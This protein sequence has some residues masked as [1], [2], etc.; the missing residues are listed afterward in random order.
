MNKSH[1][2]THGLL[3][4]KVDHVSSDHKW[5]TQEAWLILGVALGL[6]SL[7]CEEQ[8]EREFTN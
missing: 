2:L 6:L 3:S 4:S 8:F 5:L 1:N 7:L